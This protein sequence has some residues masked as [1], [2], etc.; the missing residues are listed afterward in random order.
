[1]IIFSH[2]HGD[3]T[4]K[5]QP[6]SLANIVATV[7]IDAGRL[8]SDPPSFVDELKSLV[9]PKLVRDRTGAFVKDENGYP[10]PDPESGVVRAKDDVEEFF[11]SIPWIFRGTYIW[12]EIWDDDE[13]S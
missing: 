1:M 3:Y 2:V 12:A 4:V 13:L 5:G 9:G 10:I 11:M 8:H 6:A 7:W